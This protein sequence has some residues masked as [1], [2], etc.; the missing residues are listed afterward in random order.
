[1][2]IVMSKVCLLFNFNSTYVTNTALRESNVI[3]YEEVTTVLP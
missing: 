3:I 1:M 2:N